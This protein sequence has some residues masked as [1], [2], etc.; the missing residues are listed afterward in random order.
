MFLRLRNIESIA[1]KNK[2][3]FRTSQILCYFCRMKRLFLSIILSLSLAFV[4]EAQKIA[5]KRSITHPQPMTG[6]AVW[7]YKAAEIHNSYGDCIQL[8]FN[9]FLPCRL[10]KGCQED[11]TII[12]DWS[13]FDSALS[14]VASRGHQLVARFR[15][16]YPNSDDVD[17]K[18]GSTAVPAYIK[19]LPGYQETWSDENQTYYADWRCAE[20]ERFTLQFYSDFMQRY[21]RDPRLAFLE[22]GFGHWSEYH[23]YPTKVE[24]GKN[25]PSLAF[26]KTFLLHL[27]QMADAL[28]WLVSKNAAD[29]SPIVGDNELLALSFG[30]FEDSFM[31][32]YFLKGGY[33]KAW[34]NLG[35][36]TRWHTG[37]YG[38]EI[39]PPVKE[40]FLRPGGLNGHTIDEMLFNYHIT[41]MNA[42]AAPDSQYGTPERLKQL[43]M[44]MGYHFVVKDAFIENGKTKLL[45][46][47]EGIAPIYRDAYF[48]IGDV[49]SETSL[50]ALLPGADIWV[51]IA[52]V[53]AM[54]AS[55]IKIVCDYI[56]P[57]QEIEFEAD[58]DDVT[59]LETPC[60]DAAV[61]SKHEPCYNLAGQV[62]SAP[63]K[64]VNIVGGQKILLK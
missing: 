36:Q 46:G 54:D 1:C 53:P 17:G 16:E 38:G 28:P 37:V 27:S 7:P 20:L 25:F 61:A 23:I 6:L 8:E 40:S 21:A 29:N 45:V 5:L 43:S 50:K 4:A 41:F 13:Y 26:Q 9:Y 15:Y 18:V 3:I 48:A 10:V 62:L 47:N 44:F 19:Q 64:G 52:A 14:D 42:N 2:L 33:A 30:L 49:R 57:S 55:E 22:V 32:D 12:Y 59:A 24:Y 11:G 60:F 56:L 39:Y 51:E 34:R 31:G 35:G 58:I 63:V